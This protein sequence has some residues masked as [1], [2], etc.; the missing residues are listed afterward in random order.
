MVCMKRVGAACRGAS[1]WPD[2]RVAGSALSRVDVSDCVD[3][4]HIPCVVAIAHGLDTKSAPDQHTEDLAPRA[5]LR[6]RKSGIV[7]NFP[8][9]V[10]KSLEQKEQK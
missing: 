3:V 1:V 5:L 8:I 6:S 9:A 7:C 10:P 2:R 4:V